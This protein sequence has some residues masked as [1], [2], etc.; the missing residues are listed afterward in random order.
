MFGE[1][2]STGS[3]ASNRFARHGC[4]FAAGV[5]LLFF[6]PLD[7]MV[8]YLRNRPQPAPELAEDGEQP[9][10]GIRT[11]NEHFHHGFEPL[12]SASAGVGS[13]FST[14]ALH[15]IRPS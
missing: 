1:S 10:A 12:D 9:A 4:L 8:G 14:P 15:P 11:Y 7:L 13:R 6:I 5:F 3:R 2:H